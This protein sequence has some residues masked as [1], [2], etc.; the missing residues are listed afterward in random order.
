MASSNLNENLECP[1]CM[2]NFTDKIYQCKNGHMIC[3][4]CISQLE[5]QECPTCMVSIVDRIRNRF[6]E[7]C[8][9]NN[10]LVKHGSFTES[11]EH[12]I[13]S[14]IHNNVDVESESWTENE[15]KDEQKI[16]DASDENNHVD[17]LTTPGEYLL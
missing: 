14:K 9:H 3:E 2:E 1:I 11:S 4:Q 15:S 8:L 7:E 13:F 12:D 6:A 10:K 17:H 5:K 16:N